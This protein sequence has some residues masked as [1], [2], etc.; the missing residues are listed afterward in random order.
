VEKQELRLDAGNTWKHKGFLSQADGC[1]GG[2]RMTTSQE[3]ENA[4]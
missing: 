4:L 3:P 1:C 2:R